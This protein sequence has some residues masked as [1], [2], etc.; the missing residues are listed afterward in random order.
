MLVDAAMGQY[1]PR[2]IGKDPETPLNLLWMTHRALSRWLYMRNPRAMANTRVPQYKAFAEDAVIALNRTIEEADFGRTVSE[3]VDQS[4]Y[5]VGALCMTADYVGTERGMRQKLVLESVPCPDLVWDADCRNLHDSDYL[6]RKILQKLI[7]VRDHPLYDPQARTKVGP[8]Y[9]NFKPDDEKANWQSA[10]GWMRTS[11]YDYVELYQVLDRADNRMYVWPVEQ[12]ELMLMGDVWNGPPNGFIRLLH[13]GSP[14]GHAWPVS[15]MSNVYRLANARNVLLVKALRQ[16][17]V[18]KGVL[19]YT[20]AQKEE[21]K[22]I[23]ESPDLQSA[24]QENG[25]TR[26]THVGG[27]SPDTVSMSELVGRLFSYAAGGL[28]QL[29]GLQPSAH[30][31]GQ[32][33]LLGEATAANMQ[34]MGEVVR[35]FVLKAVQDAFWF[36]IR[37]PKTKAELWKPI[38]KTGVSYPVSWTYEKRRQIQDMAFEVDVE[39]YSYRSRTPDGRLADFLG[40]LQLLNQYAPMMAAQGISL[41][42]EAIAVTI[43]AYKDLP[44]LYDALI[45]NQDPEELSRL[46]GA[47]P[48]E[49]PMNA[50][51]PQG[52]YVREDRN[53]GAGEMQELMRMFGRPQPLQEAMA[54]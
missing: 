11:L 37:D 1:Y 5:S 30:T 2:A 9:M 4:L 23:L 45:L 41:D 47:R 51:K 46:M 10:Q 33:R 40:S 42:M 53:S 12:P 21:A 31:L 36:N 52:H 7:D 32:E 39:P 48:G 20:A 16:Q 50:M 35:L 17:Q 19:L 38:G 49:T 14:P 43:A 13:Y 8:S 18:A 29:L 22:Q 44:E 24:L 3:V 6:G 26:W 28:D 25:P 34:D 54:A 15:P 27:A